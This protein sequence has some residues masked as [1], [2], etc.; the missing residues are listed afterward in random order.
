MIN[1][2]EGSSEIFLYKGV[3]NSARHAGD[4]AKFFEKRYRAH[5]KLPR[6]WTV[7]EFVSGGRVSSLDILVV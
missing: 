4:V 7:L 6:R 3:Q 2:L 1:I 5:L